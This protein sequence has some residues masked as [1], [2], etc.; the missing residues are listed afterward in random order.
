MSQ[1]ESIQ[2][3]VKE[4]LKQFADIF[5]TA[6]SH[7]NPLLGMALEHLK[8]RTGKRM[9][10][11]LVLLCARLT[12]RV[13]DAVLNA[14]AALELLHT[15]SLVHDDVVDESD[16]RRGQLSV[17][18]LSGNKVAVLVGDYL[19][20]VALQLAAKTQNTEVVGVV[21]QLGQTLADG[22][23]L[24]LANTKKQEL[25]E[26]SYYEVIRKKTASLFSACA[27]VGA[28]LAGG[29][30]EEVER[31]RR[32]GQLVGMCFQLRDDIFDFDNKADTGKPAG[33]DMKEGKLTLP[34]IHALNKAADDGMTALAMKVRRGEATAQEIDSLVAFTREQEGIAYA[35]WA[36]DEFRYM[37]AGLIPEDADQTVVEA[38]RHYVDYVAQRNK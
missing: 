10:P 11:V 27:Q 23:L 25:S 5:E 14:A 18:A 35:E 19:L 6:L 20:S 31:M 36:M 22:E 38:L 16:T 29:S 12:G 1:L 26:A 30:G 9:R 33:N 13:N 37:A 15:A 3:P 4:E 28:I 34:V 7:E 32:F 17:N 2:T 24:Q 8:K 21:A